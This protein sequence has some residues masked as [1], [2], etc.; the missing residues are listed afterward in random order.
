MKA[1]FTANMTRHE[2]FD[3]SVV[4]SKLEANPEKLWSLNEMERTGG[5]PDVVRVEE[6]TGEMVF[7]D[8]SQQSPAGR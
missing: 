3:W 7:V 4:Q 8:C 6:S 2:A 1:R 5:E